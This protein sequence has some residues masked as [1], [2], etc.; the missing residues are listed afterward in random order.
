MINM[1]YI[2]TIKLLYEEFT[3]LVNPEDPTPV[4]TIGYDYGDDCYFAD[5][6]YLNRVQIFIKKTNDNLFDI[7]I[8][9]LE[10]QGDESVFIYY[11][12]SVLD[13]EILISG[14]GRIVRIVNEVL[15]DLYKS[16]NTLLQ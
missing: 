15:S 5:I 4:Q 11:N 16:D 6:D 14:A 13:S 3:K 2:L 7:G 10:I 1:D 12:D 8:R 9:I